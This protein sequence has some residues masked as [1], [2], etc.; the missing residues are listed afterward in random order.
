[1]ILQGKG[2]VGK[3]FI[4]A[5]LAQYIGD[6]TTQLPLCIDTDP[7][8]ATFHGY[9]DLDVQRL[10]IL[11]NDE[12]NTRKF[13]QLI[14]LI[15]ETQKDVIIDNGASTY[16]PL[17]HYLITNDV[18]NLLI[19]MGHELVIHTVVTGGQALHDTLAGFAD[20]ATHFPK[21]ASL[22]VWLNPFWGAIESEGKD[23]EKMKAFTSNKDRVS[24]IVRIPNLK[25]ETFGQDLSDILQDRMT[26]NAALANKDIPIMQRQRLTMIKRQLFEQ[27]D[28]VAIL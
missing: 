28:S 26:F 5:T 6:N 21:E 19:S 8:N 15:A 9:L 2:G 3:S 12:I 22:V 7:V 23:F 27:L 17:S 13:D 16:V 25:K 4:A 10:E 1:M 24:A 11:V 20:I 18:P 14:E